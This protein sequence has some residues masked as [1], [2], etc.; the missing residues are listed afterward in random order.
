MIYFDYDVPLTYLFGHFL[1]INKNILCYKHE[2]DSLP[3][4]EKIHF[5]ILD[6]GVHTSPLPN[7]SK[8]RPKVENRKLK[9]FTSGTKE[10]S[11]R[12]NQVV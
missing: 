10:E 4:V 1:D 7:T 3:K 11:A 6:F 2:L 8:L 5:D 9:I 12:M